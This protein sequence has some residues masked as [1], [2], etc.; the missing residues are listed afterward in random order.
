MKNNKNIK[1]KKK[2]SQIIIIDNSCLIMCVRVYKC[3]YILFI[4][5]EL[6]IET[7]LRVKKNGLQITQL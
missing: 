5:G 6:Y 4:C 2:P 3:L 7:F 1:K